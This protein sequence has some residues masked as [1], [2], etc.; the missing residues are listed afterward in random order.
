MDA[1]HVLYG[2]SMGKG[3]VTKVVSRKFEDAEQP[4]LGEATEAA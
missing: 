2:V 3:G 4:A 1:A